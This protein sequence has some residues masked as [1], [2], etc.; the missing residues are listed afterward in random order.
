LNYPFLTQ[1][2]RDVETGLDYFGARNYSSTQGR[3][4]S[5]DEFTGGPEQLFYFEQVARSNPTF[6]AE[7]EE[8]Q[9]LN[10]YQYAINNPLRYVDPDGHQAM[11]DALR[12]SAEALQGAGPAG[13]TAAQ[14]LR[15]AAAVTVVGG[16][17]YQGL[18]HVI[19]N[20]I[21]GTG[22]ASCPAGI[23]CGI[24]QYMNKSNEQNSS[25]NQSQQQQSQ[26]GQSTN[27]QPN[28]KH[29]GPKGDDRKGVSPQPKAGGSLFGSATQVKPGQ[30]VA[31]DPSTGKFVVYRTDPNGQTHGYETTWQGLRNDQR[32][33][34]QKAGLVTKHGRIKQQEEG[35]Q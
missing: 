8:P 24:P 26:E 20:P 28:P 17:I 14:V 9:T 1:K 31:I 29:D 10:K 22:I 33:A 23:N 25:A 30:R 19:E 2:E 5:P 15:G 3:F 16:L 18:K 32:A 13:A 6:Y 4:T 7:L 11:A 34:L 27:Y 21:P 35:P 12:Q